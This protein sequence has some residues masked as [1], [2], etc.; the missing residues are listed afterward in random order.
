M[1]IQKSFD[2]DKATLYIVP[3]PIGNLE[4]ITYRA[5][6]ILKTVAVIA[7]EDTRN[8]RHL[9]NHFEIKT[10][11][12]SYH[13]HNKEAREEQLLHYLERGDS[14]AVVSDAGMPAISDPGYELVQAA[15][16][17]D[18]PVVVLP[19]A[20][21]AL[22]ALVGSG[23]SA[24]EFMF[25]GFL[26][27]KKK[28]KLVEL[29]RLKRHAMTVILYESPYRLKDTIKAI[30]EV[31]G[32]RK[33]VI[34]RELTKRFEEY[35]RGTVSELLIWAEE[36]ELRGEFCL[37]LEGN[38]EQEIETEELWWSH[39]SVEEHVNDYIEKEDI[40]SKEAIKRV[41]VDRGMKKRDVYQIF[42]VE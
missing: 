36:S 15:I 31:C 16:N 33:L 25:Y 19:G 29:A 3:T 27:R 4:D 13:E 5:L 1:Q 20:N 17:A 42:H 41:S 6:N 10:S 14:L 24:R 30:Y 18:Y 26:P 9:L 2:E 38:K 21:A 28:D 32:D 12:I 8:T 22:C 37:V 11:L 39:L 40:S 23:L 7:A 35:V 34:A